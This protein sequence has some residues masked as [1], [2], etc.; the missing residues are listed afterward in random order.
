MYCHRLSFS[1]PG[2]R[3]ALE[4]IRKRSRFQVKLKRYP[5]EPVIKIVQETQAGPGKKF[6]FEGGRLNPPEEILWGDAG[7]PDVQARNGEGIGF[8]RHHGAVGSIAKP[9][10]ERLRNFDQRFAGFPLRPGNLRCRPVQLAFHYISGGGQVAGHPLPV[11]FFRFQAIFPGE[12]DPVGQDGF[13]VALCGCGRTMM[14]M[15]RVDVKTHSVCLHLP[16]L[17]PGE[18]F[19]AADFFARPGSNHKIGGRQ[20]PGFQL[21]IGITVKR[22]V[23]VVER[24]Y[25]C[26][27]R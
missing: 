25:Y 16:H 13:G 10:A 15:V 17:V 26:L 11:L 1:R 6:F 2:L 22:T 24:D 20:F 5:L 23:T 12:P 19:Q 21:R 14:A 18:V 8:C 9:V 3:G 4:N 27:F 7:I